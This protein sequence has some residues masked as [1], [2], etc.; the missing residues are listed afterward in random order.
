MQGI[1]AAGGTGSG[2]GQN[3]QQKAAAWWAAAVIGSVRIEGN[4]TGGRRIS[5][6]RLR[7]R[8]F[9]GFRGIRLRRPRR[10]AI[11]TL[12]PVTGSTKQRLEPQQIISL[13]FLIAADIADIDADI[14]HTDHLTVHQPGV[15]GGSGVAASDLAAGAVEAKIFGVHRRLSFCGRYSSRHTCKRTGLS[16]VTSI[17]AEGVDYAN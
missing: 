17:L 12:C 9:P 3:G 1:T 15:G 16:P 5:R 13:I 14:R 7:T 6:L 2:N 8:G 10:R 4:S 11:F